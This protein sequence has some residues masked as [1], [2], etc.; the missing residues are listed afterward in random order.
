[1][2]L[3]SNLAL[4]IVACV[5]TLAVAENGPGAEVAFQRGHTLFNEGKY[6]DACAAFEQSEKLDPQLATQFDLA[7]CWEKLGKLA[8]AW[9]AF[10]EVAQRDT[11][12]A[13]RD[14]ASTR[15]AALEP[16]LSKVHLHATAVPGFAVTS[17]GDDVTNLLDLDTPV[18]PG[19]YRLVASATGYRTWS[20][21][22]EIT[23]PGKTVAVDVPALDK[24]VHA[25]P[26]RP[27]DPVRRVDAPRSSTAH[28]AIAIGLAGTSVIALGTGVALAV[29]ATDR[30]HDAAALCPDPAMPCADAGTAN[31][32]SSSA[33]RRAIGADVAFAVAGVSAIAAGIVWG[34]RSGVVVAPAVAPDRMAITAALRW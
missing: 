14:R 5:A 11:N 10:R 6:G 32:L 22:I 24:I 25:A 28:T 27:A 19:T 21:Q 18:D 20:A 15:A 33:R 12:K 1:M 7:Q 30:R 23:E 29:Q 9:A 16:K 26:V 3:A 31:A 34:T 8:S 4:A 2:K 17:N 13:R